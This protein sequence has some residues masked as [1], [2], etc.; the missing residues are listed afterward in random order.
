MAK[1]KTTRKPAKK[2][3]K[4]K[5]TK[6][7]TSRS[8][9]CPIDASV[10]KQPPWFVKNKKTGK[11]ESATGYAIAELE[12]KL[13]QEWDAMT[14]IRPGLYDEY[15]ERFEKKVLSN[16]ENACRRRFTSE[17]TAGV[18]YIFGISEAFCP[19][20]AKRGKAM[21]EYNANPQKAIEEQY[22]SVR[23]HKGKRIVTA[24]DYKDVKRPPLKNGTQWTFNTVGSW[25]PGDKSKLRSLKP[26]FGWVGGQ[27]GD[28]PAKA[29]CPSCGMTDMYK[30]CTKCGSEKRDFVY[31]DLIEMM[32]HPIK[33]DFIVSVKST[34][35]GGRKRTTKNLNWS[36]LTK[37]TRLY[38]DDDEEDLIAQK[39][40]L[41]F[42]DVLE[43]D[44]QLAMHKVT[45]ATIPSVHKA[46]EKDK[47]WWI[48]IECNVVNLMPSPDGRGQ[49]GMRISDGQLPLR[50]DGRGISG[51]KVK[52]PEHVWNYHVRDYIGLS[53]SVII[54]GKIDPWVIKEDGKTKTIWQ[55]SAWGVY[56]I[57]NWTM[58]PP[59]D[60]GLKLTPEDKKVVTEVIDDE[61]VEDD[62]EELDDEDGEVTFEEGDSDELE[63]G[64][65]SFEVEED[66]EEEDDEEVKPW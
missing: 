31:P 38:S 5:A 46:H 6:K 24:L 16:L 1:K 59:P 54:V 32:F 3:G 40:L 21:R 35:V 56:G 64:N 33:V 45:T 48:W 9:S 8:S 18:G 63:E 41:P 15:P 27:F 65:G 2:A 20:T 43:K 29:V 14:L 17:A 12:E 11:M 57:P 51:I 13:Q 7:T 50:R 52:L 26:F 34:V 53:S 28:T 61:E 25:S 36:T 42:H 47:N 19:I 10:L 37:P 23:K 30:F 58:A 49:Y 39:K 44:K 22:V 62:A 60:D 55:L 66:D 4:K